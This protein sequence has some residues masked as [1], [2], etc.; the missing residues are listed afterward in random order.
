MALLHND[1]VKKLII[2]P[3]AP[4]HFMRLKRPDNR[5]FATVGEV[6]VAD[7]KN[8][9]KVYEVGRDIYEPVFYFPRKDV[10]MSMLHLVKEK[11]TFCPLKGTTKYFDVVV[12]G[13]SYASAAWSYYKPVEFAMDLKDFIAF[14]CSVVSIHEDAK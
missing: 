7:S 11:S 8:V 13:H 9:I 5:I 14:D 10:E 2:R 1:L 6:Q 3:D 12:A 4:F